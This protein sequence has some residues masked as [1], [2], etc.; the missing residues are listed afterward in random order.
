MEHA[1]FIDQIFERCVEQRGLADSKI[2]SNAD[3]SAS[4]GLGFLK[5]IPKRLD[6]PFAAY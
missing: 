5:R 2:S 6:F 3:Q 1:A 4:V